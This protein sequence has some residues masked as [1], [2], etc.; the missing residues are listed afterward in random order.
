MTA[1]SPSTTSRPDRR[2][3]RREIA[4]ALVVLTP[5]WTLG[6]ALRE[7]LTVLW[8]SLGAATAMGVAAVL[9]QARH[10]VQPRVGHDVWLALPAAVVHLAVSYVAIPVATAIVPLIGEQAED[11][12]VGAT[13]DLPVLVV[14]AISAF[15][16][17]PLEEL[18]WRGAVQ[19][20]LGV[21]RSPLWSV[22]ITT[23][24]F[25][26]FHLPT[27]QLPLISAA[28]LGGLVWGW[29]RERTDGLLAPVI[30][31]AIWTGAMVL[32]PPT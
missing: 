3:R 6:V 14:A 16:I 7:E 12:V 27:L 29:L 2:I 24:V 20:S 25:M 18:F 26:G 23:A 28:A 10:R 32:V 31:H 9:L 8:V 17:A 19:P 5:L 22:L 1:T 15:A 11:I 4:L 30:A 21:G 13:G